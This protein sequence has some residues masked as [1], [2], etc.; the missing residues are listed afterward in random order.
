MDFKLTVPSALDYFQSLVESD[1]S[2]PLLEAAA[3]L[4]QD[5]YPDLDIQQVLGDMD[6]LI[7]KFK[8]RMYADMGEIEKLR[9]LNLFFFEDLKFSGNVNHYDDPDNSFLHAVFR[10]RKGIPISLAVIWLELASG[11]GL[12]V[13]GVGFPGHFLVK[14][15]LKSP[16]E[17]QILID[18]FSGQSLGREDL[19]ERLA[20]WLPGVQLTRPNAV[21]DDALAHFL[22]PATPREIIAR[23]L[24]N[25]QEIY[26]RQEDGARLKQV[27]SRLNILLNTEII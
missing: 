2:F 22:R 16:N 11:V 6:Q 25:L 18:P 5:E 9:M 10:T 23:M 27:Q 20:P 13:Q 21:S 17:A 12:S 24:R 15:Q 4:A 19:S 1:D 8:R 26:R 3:S 14:V 7:A